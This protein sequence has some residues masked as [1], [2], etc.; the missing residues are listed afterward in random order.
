MVTLHNSCYVTF[1]MVV[2]G[3][4]G[5]FSFNPAMQG[6]SPC[7]WQTAVNIIFLFAGL[8]AACLY[9]NIGVK[10][11]LKHHQDKSFLLEKKLLEFLDAR[12]SQTTKI[13]H[14]EERLKNTSR[15]QLSATVVFDLPAGRKAEPLYRNDDIYFVDHPLDIAVEVWAL[16]N[17]EMRSGAGD[18]CSGSCSG[19]PSMAGGVVRQP[20]TQIVA[21]FSL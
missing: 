9:G 20:S 15:P 8:I 18:W 4:Q 12:L 6:L 3:F 5:Q 2:Y 13:W 16:W 21:P 19:E 14:G 11:S 17:L 7:N 10:A 1:G